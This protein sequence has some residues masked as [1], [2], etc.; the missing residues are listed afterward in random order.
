MLDDLNAQL[1]KHG[2]WFPGRRLDRRA[3]DARRHDRQQL[4]RLALDRLRL[5]GAPRRGHRRLPRRRHARALRAGRRRSRTRRS[6]RCRSGRR[7]SGSGRRTR[8]RRASRRCR[9]AWP[10]YNL[11]CLAPEGQNLAKLLVGSEGTLAWFERI[12]LD[13][14]DDPEAQGARRGALPAL[15]RRDGRRAAHREAGALRRG[16]GGPHDDRALA[17]DSRLRAHHRRLRAR[18]ARRD[19][20]G[21]VRRRATATSRCAA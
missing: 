16:A 7:R 4:L 18:R 21:G 5:H 19:P 17:R 9:A 8:S 2:L 12:T 3:G 1:R 20:A 6:A 11:D 10:G 15:L 14:A 13:L